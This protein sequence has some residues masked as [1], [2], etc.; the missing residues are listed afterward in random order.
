MLGIWGDFST[1]DVQKLTEQLFGAWSPPPSHLKEPP[2]KE[3]R[4]EGTADEAAGTSGQKR[5]YL[6]DKPGLTQG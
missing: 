3:Y 4:E 5:V 6:V 1:S 2:L